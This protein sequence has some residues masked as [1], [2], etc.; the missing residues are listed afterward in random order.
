M[1]AAHLLQRAGG[2]LPG[3][4]GRD[5]RRTRAAPAHRPA[6]WSAMRDSQR[7]HLAA[8]YGGIALLRR[9]GLEGLSRRRPATLIAAATHRDT[10]ALSD[11]LG[12]APLHGFRRG[13]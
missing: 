10:E 4:D 11:R 1:D 3:V 9:S 12:R 2:N 8:V 5:L 13:L 7:P 6:P